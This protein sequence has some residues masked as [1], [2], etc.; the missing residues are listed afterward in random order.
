M[1]LA[2]YLYQETENVGVLTADGQRI[3]PLRAFG[4]ACTDMVS[5]IKLLDRQQVAALTAR[6]AAGEAP[7]ALPLD[8]EMIEVSAI[9]A[10]LGVDALDRSLI[11]GII[12]IALVMLFMIIMYRVPGLMSCLLTSDMQ[13]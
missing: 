10:T 4:F 5:A 7:G 9:S 13:E 3:C 11:A 12:G 1:K 8:I 2:T 6:L